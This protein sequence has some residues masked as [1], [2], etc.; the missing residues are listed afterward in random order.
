MTRLKNFFLQYQLGLPIRIEIGII[1]KVSLKIPW[2]GLFS[3]P[4]IL[5]IEVITFYFNNNEQT[6]VTT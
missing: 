5:C 2:A 3:Q 1:G 4:I 6:T